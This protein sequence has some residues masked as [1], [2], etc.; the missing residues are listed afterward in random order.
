M[1][2]RYIAGKRLGK[3]ALLQSGFIFRQ[4]EHQPRAYVVWKLFNLRD[5]LNLIMRLIEFLFLD[6][7]LGERA[8]DVFTR[9]RLRLLQQLLGL[10]S[11]DRQ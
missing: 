10:C 7:H 3:D 8:H 4:R 11:I 5:L 9:F 1:N 2:V 6:I